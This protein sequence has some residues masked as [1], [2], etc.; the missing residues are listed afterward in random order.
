MEKKS[1]KELIR[2]IQFLLKMVVEVK[3]PHFWTQT[4]VL[5]ELNL[6][7]SVYYKVILYFPFYFPSFFGKV[8][9]GAL[10]LFDF[11][12]KASWLDFYTTFTSYIHMGETDI[13]LDWR[14]DHSVFFHG[15]KTSHEML[16]VGPIEIWSTPLDLSYWRNKSQRLI[17]PAS[18]SH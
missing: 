8:R 16:T 15:L 1:K 10:G 14:H 9:D 18:V 17:S 6:F 5:P 12:I 7:S 2:S 3:V 13:H 4:W 11:G